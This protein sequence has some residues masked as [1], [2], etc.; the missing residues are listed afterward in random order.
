VARGRKG[1]S[2]GT[3]PH[4]L[5]IGPTATPSTTP[6]R[7]SRTHQVIREEADKFY[8]PNG[9][10]DVLTVDIIAALSNAVMAR[11]A[12][13]TLHRSTWERALDRKKT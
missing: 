8:G 12:R 6:R 5:I 11:L 13:K 3:I 4:P 7:R 10:Q 9:W 2:P 1:W